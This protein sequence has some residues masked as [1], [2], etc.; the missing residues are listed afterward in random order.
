MT[1]QFKSQSDS[2]LTPG[3]ILYDS[4]TQTIKIK[5]VKVKEIHTT[6]IIVIE[7]ENDF[8]WSH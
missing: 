6:D 1:H 5:I 8:N 3:T 4:N 7:Q 2:G